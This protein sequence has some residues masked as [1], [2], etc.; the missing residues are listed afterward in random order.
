MMLPE[1][2]DWNG[3]HNPDHPLFVFDGDDGKTTVTWSQAVRMIHGAAYHV[4][5]RSQITVQGSLRPP[6]VAVLATSGT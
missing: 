6:V 3:T 1:I 2:Y 5:D 4:T